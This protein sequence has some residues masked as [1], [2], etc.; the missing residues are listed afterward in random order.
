MLNWPIC[1]LRG[2]FK[3]LPR[4]DLNVT[5]RKKHRKL[6]DRHYAGGGGKGR[7]VCWMPRSPTLDLCPRP[8]WI[9]DICLL[10]PPSLPPPVLSKEFDRGRGRNVASWSVTFF[11]FFNPNTQML[12]RKCTGTH[13]LIKC[14]TNRMFV[15]AHILYSSSELHFPLQVH[16]LLFSADVET[17]RLHPKTG[18]PPS[19]LILVCSNWEVGL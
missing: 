19:S 7:R 1:S 18:P 2:N 17:K 11:V 14:D 10:F 5:V 9:S 8:P 12:S 15:A 4:K 3:A 13:T 6:N 16:R